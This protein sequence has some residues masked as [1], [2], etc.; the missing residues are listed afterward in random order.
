[1][2]A[3]SG[4]GWARSEEGVVQHEVKWASMGLE[5][6]GGKDLAAGR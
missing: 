3:E 6:D 4:Q 5:R 1:M 2:L